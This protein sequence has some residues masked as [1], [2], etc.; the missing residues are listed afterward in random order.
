MK[1]PRGDI[2]GSDD[3]KFSP[4][5]SSLEHSNKEKRQTWIEKQEEDF[6][7]SSIKHLSCIVVPIIGNDRPCQDEL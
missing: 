3:L 1:N 4:L 5:V 2:V 6:S 7:S